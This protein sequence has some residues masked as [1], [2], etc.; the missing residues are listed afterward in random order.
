[1][2]LDFCY[3]ERMSIRYIL[4]GGNAQDVNDENDLFF[5]KILEP[6]SGQ[7]K[8]LLVQF[9]A[10]S[11]KQ[12]IYKERHI[13]QFNRSK[14]DRILSFQVA[15]EMG[16]DE[17]LEWADVVYLSGSSGGTMRLLNVL[18]QVKDLGIKLQGKTVAGESAGAN[19]L[20]AHCFSRSG[21][22]IPCLGLVP[23]DFIPHY[24]SGDEAAL[25]SLND[26]NE[27]LYLKNYEFR[28]F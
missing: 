2:L 20:S 27:H 7:V 25:R 3:T 15:D 28:V 12:D 8:V 16:F 5:K 10:I 26:D 18:S 24:Q 11:E 17:Q 4:H 23:V 19:V 22:V 1:M 14:G 13:G 9:A 6:F 21:G